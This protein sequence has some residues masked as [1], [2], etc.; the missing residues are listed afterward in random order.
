MKQNKVYTISRLKGTGKENYDFCVT[1]HF[2]NSGPL[3]EN[4]NHCWQC[5]Y[6]LNQV[7]QEY[8]TDALSFVQYVTFIINIIID[9]YDNS[10]LLRSV[11]YF[12]IDSSGQLI[13][14][15]IEDQRS[16]TFSVSKL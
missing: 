11:D 7:L 4:P 16:L 2:W 14:S 3:I 15:M 8:E 6:S 12:V 10:S 9:K 1:V 13:F 5:A